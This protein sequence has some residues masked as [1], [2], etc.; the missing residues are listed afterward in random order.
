M[1][2]WQTF[3]LFLTFLYY[4]ILW[5]SSIIKLSLKLWKWFFE[6]AGVRRRGER[7]LGKL[8]SPLSLSLLICNNGNH[9]SA[10]LI[11]GV[12]ESVRIYLWSLK[13]TTGRGDAYSS[14]LVFKGG[15]SLDSKAACCSEQL[16][17][18][19]QHWAIASKWLGHMECLASSAALTLSQS[20][21]SPAP[22]TN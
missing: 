18:L 5:L 14:D 17:L 3:R 19:W 6:G 16:H 7:S 10:C 12:W 13:L 21:M 20:Q 22:Y 2:Y 15:L 4:K 1:F 11:G 8:L 9:P